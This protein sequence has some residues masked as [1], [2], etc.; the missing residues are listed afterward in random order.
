MKYAVLK[1]INGSYS[2][3]AEGFT[4]LSLAKVNYHEV[5]KTLWSA[6]DVTTARVMIVDEQLSCIDNCRE[7]IYHE[8]EPEPE[9]EPVVET[10]TEET[11]TEETPTEG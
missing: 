10:T 11:P 8:P 1:C 5:C 2:V 3:H 9:P 6:K 4:D 7:Y